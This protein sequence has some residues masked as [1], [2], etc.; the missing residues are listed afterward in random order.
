MLWSQQV[1]ILRSIGKAM[2]SSSDH[3]L[4]A[5]VRGR[6]SCSTLVSHTLKY[7]LGVM[8]FHAG[9][10]LNEESKLRTAGRRVFSIAATGDTS[11]KAVHTAYQGVK[12]LNF[13]KMYHRKDIG[14]R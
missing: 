4:K 3:Y 12:S 11:E 9:T 10:G 2:Q 14:S 13:D 6:I 5:N 8:T 7:R 1:A